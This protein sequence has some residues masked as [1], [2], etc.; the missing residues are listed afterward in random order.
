MMYLT[1]EIHTEEFWMKQFSRSVPVILFLGVSSLSLIALAGCGSSGSNAPTAA[2]N[3]YGIQTSYNETIQTEQDSVMV[4][5]ASATGS[6]TPTSTLALPNGFEGT[7]LTVGPTGTIYVG[8]LPNNG[9]TN[10]GQI[11]EYPAGSSGSATP[12]VTLSGA[13]GSFEAP[14]SM[15][16]NTAGTLFVSSWDGTLEAFASG[17]TASSAPTQYLTWGT[18]TNATT[19]YSNFNW[20]GDNIGVDTAGDV[21][22]TDPGNS[23]IDVFAAGATGATAPTREITGTNTTSFS[24]PYYLAVDGAGDVYAAN[25]NASNDPNFAPVVGTNPVT[26]PASKASKWLQALGQRGASRLTAHPHDS[27]GTVEPTEIIEFAAGASG[28]ATPTNRIGGAGAATNATNI[29]EP[30]GLAVDASSN[31]Y[32]A[33]ANGGYA[34]GDNDQ[35]LLEVFAPSATGNVAPAASMTSTDIIYGSSAGVA[36]Y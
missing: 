18:Q 25:Y 36:V 19:G 8:G 22:Y 1:L 15:A 10:F 12:S 33:D 28:N 30:L 11:L 21:F 24:D 6:T 29:V 9:D 2:K 5:S 20:W 27:D 26:Y 13:S 17:S 4:F 3:V 34:G 14:G 31:L 23:V 35:V 16:V 7:A 32:Y